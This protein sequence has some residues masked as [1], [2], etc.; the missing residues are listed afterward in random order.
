MGATKKRTLVKMITYKTGCVLLFW[1]LSGS[2][3]L[4]IIYLL[5]TCV[6]YFFHD[7]VWKKIFWGKNHG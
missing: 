1:L 7:R 6:W 5:I 4:S 2:V 3:R